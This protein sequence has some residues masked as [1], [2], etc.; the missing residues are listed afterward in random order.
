[1][2]KRKI[3]IY[4]LINIYIFLVLGI[5]EGIFIG[6][7]F[8]ILEKELNLDQKKKFIIILIFSLLYILIYQK[9]YFSKNIELNQNI[10]VKIESELVKEDDYQ[11]FNTVYKGRKYE[12]ITFSKKDQMEKYKYGDIL[13]LKVNKI[14]KI[15]NIYNNKSSFNNINYNKSK[16]IRWV[17]NTKEI[18]YV[19]SKPSF[20]NKM[21]NIR[22]NEIIKLKKLLPKNYSIISALIF[23]DDIEK[24]KKEEIKKIGI[25]QLFTISGMHISF[26]IF[27][28]EKLLRKI[29]LETK[30]KKIIIC[31]ILYGYLPLGGSGNSIKRAVLMFYISTYYYLN[32]QKINKLD[33]LLKSL[34][35]SLLIN[36]FKLL[37]VGFV[38]TYL[39][40]F[41]LI[42]TN[43]IFKNKNYKDKIYSNYFLS[44][45]IFPITINL[46]NSFNILLPFI[47][48]IYDKIVYFLIINSF[49]LLFSINLKFYLLIYIIKMIINLTI[50]FMNLLN[51]ITMIFVIKIKSLTIIYIIIFY[52]LYYLQIKEYYLFK[53]QSKI[54]LKKT[55]IF[56]LFLSL[57][58]NI[59]GSIHV[60][61]VGQG[62]SIYIQKPFSENI[63]IDTGPKKSEKELIKF[64]D[65]KGITRI[66]NLI[67]THNHEDHQ[68]NLESLIEKYKIKKI[69]LNSNTYQTFKNK[70]KNIKVKIISNSYKNNLGYF[71]KASKNYEEE[72]NNSIV[73]LTEFANK[74]WLFMGDLEKEVE[75]EIIEKYQIDIDYLKV[76]H[77]GSKT[78]SS[79]EFLKITK[80][81]KA[82]I[83]SGKNNIYNHPNKEV[84]ENLQELNIK[85]ENT[86][87]KGEIIKYFL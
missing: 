14:Q 64:L 80:P 40:S 85:Y 5:L 15:E 67:I 9:I 3:I 24:V 78:S 38:L 8:L 13:K 73:F 42:M 6:I 84:I 50:F 59:I 54:F 48:N 23:G 71:Y 81:K 4:L 29:K 45:F 61:D 36:P 47:L 26:L 74:K 20:N 66:D 18:T 77:H 17:I 62:D 75:E 21:Q 19:K 63:L 34:I 55:I 52:I 37:N 60:I 31:I 58:V 82:Y 57:N 56:V 12:I 65:S 49:L 53:G 83:S 27:L 68:G 76:G 2:N 32:D 44:M 30:Y 51:F 10:I 41:Y 69:Y 79:K 28:L 70:I 39:I 86:Q 16:R 43:K 35:I 11:K 46:N 72:N 22:E 1:M 87:D 25:I 33:V 7:S